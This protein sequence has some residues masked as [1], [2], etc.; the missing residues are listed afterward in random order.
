MTRVSFDLLLA[1]VVGLAG[2]MA[3]GCSGGGGGGGG[4]NPGSLSGTWAMN[5]SGARH[6]FVDGRGDSEGSG[7]HLLLLSGVLD[8]SEGREVSEVRLDLVGGPYESQTGEVDATGNVEIGDETDLSGRV[9]A[10]KTYVVDPD[11]PETHATVDFDSFEYDNADDS[12]QTTG[13]FEGAFVNEEDPSER[14]EVS[15]AFDY[16]F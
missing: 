1:C 9:V 13:T 8:V 2:V 12:G 11:D 4:V 10:Q 7:E 16:F 6:V 15:G 3:S 14:I 5:I